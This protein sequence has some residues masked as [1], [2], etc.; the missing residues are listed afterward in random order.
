M[1]IL[2]IKAKIVFLVSEIKNFI[3]MEV[4]VV[5]HIKIL[6]TSITTEQ[7]SAHYP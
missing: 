2:E 1:R 4:I 5:F 3:E 7:S 6:P